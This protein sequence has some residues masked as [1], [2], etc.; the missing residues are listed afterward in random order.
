MAL[1][2]L[3]ID[4]REEAVNSR[5]RTQEVSVLEWNVVG[6]GEV[7]AVYLRER[8]ERKGSRGN[9]SCVFIERER[10]KRVWVVL[11]KECR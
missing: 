2:L 8:R 9:T 10:V 3:S 1:W 11:L 4:A 7:S 5:E 6:V